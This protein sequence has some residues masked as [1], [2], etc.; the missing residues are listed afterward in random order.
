WTFRE[1]TPQESVFLG[2]LSVGLAWL[3]YRCIEKPF[4]AG[5]HLEYDRRFVL[6]IATAF[7]LVV[8]PA[9]LTLAGNGL[10]WRL[11]YHMAS[12]ESGS[13]RFR[14]FCKSIE[15][16]GSVPACTIG[17]VGPDGPDIVVIGDSH[18]HALAPGLLPQLENSSET[19]TVLYKPGL[20][21]FLNV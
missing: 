1:L 12:S 16:P 17:D 2:F 21:P 5:G 19:A 7:V 13:P 15:W 9:S 11:P 3:M 20:L 14:D 6:S 10:E 4:R 18:V 8:M